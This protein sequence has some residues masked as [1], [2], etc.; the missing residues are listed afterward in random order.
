[1]HSIHDLFP[2]NASCLI[3]PL[4]AV[5]AL[6]GQALSAFR[7]ERP[8][9]DE[10][11]KA[12]RFQVAE[13]TVPCGSPLRGRSLKEIIERYHLFIV[14]HTPINGVDRFPTQV[15]LPAHLPSPHHPPPPT[16]P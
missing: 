8:G 9:N 1:C 13:L 5:K 2:R 7:V 16:P 14:V 6:S 10:G 15:H 4:L 11:A 12:E 3:A